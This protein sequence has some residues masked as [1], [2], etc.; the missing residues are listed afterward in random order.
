[1]RDDLKA[2][3]VLDALGMAVTA[4]GIGSAGVIAHS[5]YGSQG[6]FN[7]SSQRSSRRS[8]DE[9]EESEVGS[10]GSA[11]DAVAGPSAGRASA[12]SSAVLGGDR[13]RFVERGRGCRGGGFGGGWCPVVPGR[14]RDAVTQEGS[15]VGPLPVL[16]RA[17]GDRAL[18][19]PRLWRGGDRAS[20][21]SFALD[22]LERAASQC[23]DPQRVA[24]VSGQ[25]RAV[26]R[27]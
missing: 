19:R 13:S 12:A 27:R 24:R 4:R 14:W 26:A 1:M 3:L 11:G 23:R 9:R 2:E 7:R 17:G 10:G 20:D 25:H 15:I 21:R 18:A 6:E 16:C 22:D 5:D 8:C